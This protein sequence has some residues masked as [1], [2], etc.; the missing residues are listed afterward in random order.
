MPQLIFPESKYETKGS[1]K[2]DLQKRRNGKKKRNEEASTFL[3]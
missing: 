3:H 2:I 1:R